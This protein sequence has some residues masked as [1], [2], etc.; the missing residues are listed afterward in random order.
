MNMRFAKDKKKSFESS[1]GRTKLQSSSLPFKW[2]FIHTFQHQVLYHIVSLHESKL[3]NLLLS[4]PIF[5]PNLYAPKGIRILVE[6]PITI[7]KVLFY[8]YPC[9]YQS[10]QFFFSTTNLIWFGGQFW[11]QT[12]LAPLRSQLRGSNLFKF[13]I[14]WIDLLMI[15]EFLAEW[16]RFSQ[17]EIEIESNIVMF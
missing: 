13:T 1:K 4:L 2:I 10:I 7:T 6:T 9:P 14:N 11:P 12:V 5:P 16:R 15:L 17:L 8:G 3:Y